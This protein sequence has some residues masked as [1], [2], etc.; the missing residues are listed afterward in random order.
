MSEEIRVTVEGISDP[1]A[2]RAA[3]E[4][5]RDA[6]VLELYRLGRVT[7]GHG[8]RLLGIERSDFLSLAAAHRISTLQET[9]DELREDVAARSR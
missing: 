8:A 6:V 3:T 2:L 5:A 1:E 4:R 7:S 9:P